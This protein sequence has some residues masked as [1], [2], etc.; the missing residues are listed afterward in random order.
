[1]VNNRVGAELDRQRLQQKVVNPLNQLLQM[2]M[3][4]LSAELGSARETTDGPALATQLDSV[5]PL[6]VAVLQQMEQIL[7]EM[8]KVENAQEVERGLK[9]II[10]MS[11]QVREMTRPE[12]DNT[13]ANDKREKENDQ[14]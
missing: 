9:T 13:T 12:D 10:R 5:L 4:R 7:A 8:I 1:M 3:P 2:A 11:E 6:Q 14:P